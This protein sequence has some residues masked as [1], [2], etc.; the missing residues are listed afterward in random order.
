[1]ISA[2]SERLNNRPVSLVYSFL[3]LSFPEFSSSPASTSCAPGQFLCV[4]DGECVEEEFV[5][6]AIPDCV[7]GSDETGCADSAGTA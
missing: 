3:I 5:C 2:F 6:D 4:S 7:D 1:M